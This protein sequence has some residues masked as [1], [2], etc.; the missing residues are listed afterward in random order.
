LVTIVVLV[1]FG[2]GEII[3]AFAFFVTK[4]WK[5]TNLFICF[6]SIVNCVSFWL[7]VPESPRWL[8]AIKQF[9]EA[10]ESLKQIAKVN[11]KSDEFD[12]TCEMSLLSQEKEAEENEEVE[13]KTL[14]KQIVYPLGNFYKTFAFFLLW[15]ILNMVYIGV[16]LGILNVIDMN[17]YLTFL[18]SALFEIFGALVCF[19]NYNDAFRVS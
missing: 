15:N 11:G 8:A 6:Y 10:T 4:N 16:A 17:P 18:L 14:L 7:C 3:L 13:V 19:F 9:D 1:F 5:L 12:R 2:L